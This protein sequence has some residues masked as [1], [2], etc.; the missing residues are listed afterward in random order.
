M[1]TVKVDNALI[2]YKDFLYEEIAEA[3]SAKELLSLLKHLHGMVNLFGA[4]EYAY[5]GAEIAE[6]I[7]CR[8]DD[9]ERDHWASRRSFENVKTF[10]RQVHSVF[11]GVQFRTM[12]PV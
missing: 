12:H 7:Y 8:A 3:E 5:K 4:L 9:L 11:N 10:A 6:R 2:Q 1:D